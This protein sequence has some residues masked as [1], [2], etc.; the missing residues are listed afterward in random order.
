MKYK[1]N[2]ELAEYLS[3]INPHR[4]EIYHAIA[5][6]LGENKSCRSK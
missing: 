1:T 2:K 4:K 3:F 6:F 5:D